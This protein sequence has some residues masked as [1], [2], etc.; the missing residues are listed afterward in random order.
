M[1]L[2]GYIF[3]QMICD[4]ECLITNLEAKW[5]GSVHDSR[6]FQASR[7]YQ[8]LS[9]GKPPH[10]LKHL[11]HQEYS[12]CKNYVLYSQLSSLVCCWGTKAMPVRHF[13]WLPLQTPKPQYSKLTTMPMPRPGLELKWPSASWNHD[14]S[15]CTPWGSPQKEHVTWLLPAQC[16]TILQA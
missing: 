2:I 14:F 4:A 11:E 10:F 8:R 6:I 15:A 9:L 1:T 3:L 5:P 16:C 13:W 12:T 7:I